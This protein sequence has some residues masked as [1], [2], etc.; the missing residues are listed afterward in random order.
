MRNI[1]NRYN[2]AQRLEFQKTLLCLRFYI[3]PL[4]LQRQNNSCARC[5]KPSDKYEIDHKVYNPMVTLNELQALCHKCHV[6]I[7]DYTHIK[8]R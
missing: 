4:L 6:Q 3:M 8:N 5:K 7:T 1:R 2:L